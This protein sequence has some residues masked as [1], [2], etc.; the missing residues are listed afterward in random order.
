MQ[1]QPNSPDVI[2]LPT[3][4]TIVTAEQIEAMPIGEIQSDFFALMNG[5]VTAYGDKGDE[6]SQ[7]ATRQQ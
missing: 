5:I 2:P 7:Q 1:G 4:A 3:V 6:T